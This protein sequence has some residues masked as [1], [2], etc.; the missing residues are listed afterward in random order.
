MIRILF[1]IT[2]ILLGLSNCSS[3]DRIEHIKQLMIEEQI[4]VFKKE[5]KARCRQKALEL[6]EKKADSIMLELAIYLKTDSF[7]KPPRP[8][9]PEFREPILQK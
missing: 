9:K 6:A 1:S 3:P 2:I 4:A 5:H 8:I 7:I